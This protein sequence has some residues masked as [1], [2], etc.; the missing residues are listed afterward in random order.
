MCFTGV[1][2][3]NIGEGLFTVEYVTCDH[4]TKENTSL[5]LTVIYCV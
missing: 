2:Y 1:V 5:S 4:T 3:R